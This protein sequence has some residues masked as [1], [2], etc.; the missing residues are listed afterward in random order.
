MALSTVCLLSVARVCDVVYMYA[1]VDDAPIH[2]QVSS[3][4]TF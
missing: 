1:V 3:E 2:V 4:I